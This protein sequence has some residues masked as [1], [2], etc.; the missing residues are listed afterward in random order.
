MRRSQASGASL[1][2]A[3]EAS[4][5]RRLDAARREVPPDE[6]RAAARRSRDPI[7]L[8]RSLEG[9]FPRVL[10]EVKLASPSAG[11]LG[12]GLDPVS[13]ADAYRLNGAAA[14]SVLTEPEY[15]GGGLGVLDAVRARVAL[16]LLMKDFVLDEYQLWQARVHGADGVL[17]IAA[18]VGEAALRGLIVAAFDLGLTPLAEVHDEAELEAAVRAGATLVGVN[19]RDL[20]SLEVDL[21]VSRRLAAAPRART[22]ALISESGIRSRREIDELAGLGYRGFLVGTHLVRSGDPGAALASL[23]RQ[24]GEGGDP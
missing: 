15:F 9:P 2:E 16:P 18:L 11:S 19:N 12:A 24:D 14:I 20:R 13:L 23:L 5:R 7:D 22:V 10:A 3:I 21:G 4:T 17:L 8:A 1:L 6:M